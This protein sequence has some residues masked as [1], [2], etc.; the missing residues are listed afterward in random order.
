VSQKEA[1]KHQ[2]IGIGEKEER[3]QSSFQNPVRKNGTQMY[4]TNKSSENMKHF[5]VFI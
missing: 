1:R 3:K 2:K 4:T 5:Y